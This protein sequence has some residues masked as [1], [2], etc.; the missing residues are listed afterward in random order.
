MLLA[1][2]T[3]TPNRAILLAAHHTP[4]QTARHPQITPR[5]DHHLRASYGRCMLSLM[6]ALPAPCDPAA[7]R[8][9][10]DI[11]CATGLSSLA[12]AELFPGAAITGIDLSPHMV[13]VGRYHQQQREV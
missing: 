11:G 3:T 8:S 10:L 4:N 7:V 6:Q 13:A 5:G 12:L 1:H 2:I 9:V